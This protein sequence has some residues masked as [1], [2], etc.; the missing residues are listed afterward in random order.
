MTKRTL[1]IG[2]AWV[3]DM[4][5]AQC[6]FKTIKQLQPDTL[7]DVMAPSWTLPLLERMTEV[8][9]GLILPL[10]HGD[11]GFRRR[12][13]IGKSLRSSSYDQSIVL[14]NS[15]KSAVIPW[16]AKIPVRTGWL[17]EQRYFL[18]NDHRALDKARYPL[19]IERF[20]ALALDPDQ[21]LPEKIPYPEFSIRSDFVEAAIQKHRLDLSSQQPIIALSPGAE[22]G[23]SKRWPAR[24]FAS[25]AD[26]FLQKGWAVWIFGSP[27]DVPI[28]EDIQRLVNQRCVNLVGKTNL[29]EAI[30]LL[31]LASAAVSNDSG[32]MHVASALSIP[33][34]V[35]Y[36]STSPAF[37]PPLS[38][39]AKIVSTSIECAPCFKR[40]CPLVHHRCMKE[41][42]PSKVLAE[43]ET[44]KMRQPLTSQNNATA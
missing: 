35:V 19:M 31:S 33:Q 23:P 29:A 22:F 20:V 40:E 42:S 11:W 26:H 9:Q 16:A 12:M 27:K 4:I 1:I 14:P 7:I 8:N 43:L 5:M 25:V 21:P 41:L 30:D 36:G 10:A 13:A 39:Q 18:L 2:P 6:L 24:H 28:S 3:G 17:G 38:E 34:V 37:T 32:L 15:W 44:L